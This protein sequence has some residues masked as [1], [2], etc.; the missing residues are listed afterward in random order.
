MVR[1]L[2]DETLA[3]GSY[4]RVWDGRDNA[5]RAMASGIYFYKFVTGDFSETR[6]I[7]LLK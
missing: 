3:R 7:V 6:K 1:I 4:T 2:A 5:G